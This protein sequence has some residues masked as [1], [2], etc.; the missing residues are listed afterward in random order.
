VRE[1]LE[2]ALR[3]GNDTQN[4]L[5]HIKQLSEVEKGFTYRIAYDSKGSP[6]GFVWQTPLMR[7]LS[8]DFG[9]LLCASAKLC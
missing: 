6:T 1:L 4:I 2:E 9:D 3:R 8:E 5:F 7:K